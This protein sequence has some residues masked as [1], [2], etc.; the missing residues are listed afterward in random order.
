[1]KFTEGID[2][3]VLNKPIV[4][5]KAEGGRELGD[6][7]SLKGAH[8]N[9]AFHM[10]FQD[11]RERDIQGF[12]IGEGAGET[13]VLSLSQLTSKIKGMDESQSE[14]M[15]DIREC[16]TI[17]ELLEVMEGVEELKVVAVKEI[18]DTFRPGQKRTLCLWDTMKGRGSKR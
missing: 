1:M 10:V 7:V 5:R 15:T 14:L 4:V 2:E 13:L 3:S 9:D 11:G 17:G 8:Y 18:D 12:C 16:S 6:V